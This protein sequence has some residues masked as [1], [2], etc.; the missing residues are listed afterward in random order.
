VIEDGEEF[1]EQLAKWIES[2]PA[3]RR[4]IGGGVWRYVEKERKKSNEWESTTGAHISG[5]NEPYVRKCYADVGMRVEDFETD[6]MGGIKWTYDDSWSQ[7][8]M[9]AHREFIVAT[10]FVRN[11]GKFIRFNQRK[12]NPPVIPVPVADYDPLPF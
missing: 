12:T 11:P 5:V 4:I 6:D 2:V 1:A 10:E 3:G 7:E 9:D 8:E